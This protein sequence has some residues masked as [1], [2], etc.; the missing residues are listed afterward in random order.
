M[1]GVRDQI[2]TTAL[3]G[4]VAMSLYFSVMDPSYLMSLLF[5]FIQVMNPFHLIFYR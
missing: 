5:C 2:A 3:L 1:T 4:S